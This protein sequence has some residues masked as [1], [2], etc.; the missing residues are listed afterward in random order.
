MSDNIERRVL[1]TEDVELRVERD[2]E[3]K[4]TKITGYAAVFNKN[5]VNFG[6]LVEQIKPGAFANTLK[7]SDVRALVNHDSNLLLG[8]T[9]SGTLRMT[10]NSKG[11]KFEVDLPNNNAARDAAE[12]IDRGDMD[13]CS[14]AF[15]IV[16]D[17]WREGKD[18]DPDLRTVVEVDPL[19]DVGPVTYPAYPDTSVAVRSHEQW[20]ETRANDGVVVGEAGEITPESNEG[21]GP[22]KDEREGKEPEEKESPADVDFDAA[23][24]ARIAAAHEATK[25][26][27]RLIADLHCNQAT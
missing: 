11:L 12:S 19:F 1:P 8:R 21:P 25:S 24:K 13:G 2:S 6:G 7:S 15:R 4:P 23:A 10:E 18:G 14:F 16:A 5:S 22:A 3:G 20:K 9:K 17:E 27:N 26:I